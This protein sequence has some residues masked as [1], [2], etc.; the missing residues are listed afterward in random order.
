MRKVY[1]VGVG[2]T[3]FGEL[4]ERSFRDLFVEAGIRAIEDAGVDGKEIE[5]LYIGNMSAGLLV[6]QEHVASLIADH[7][8]LA[9]LHIPATRVEGGDASGALALVQGFSSIASGMY[10]V[11]VV[12]GVEK[13][14]DVMAEKASEV[15]ATTLDQEW[16]AFFGMTYASAYALMA[17]RHMHEFGTT[18]EQMALVSVKNHSNGSKN[19]MAHFRFEVSLEKVLSSPIVSYPIKLL[20]SHAVSDGASALVLCSEKKAKEFESPVEISGIG[21]ASDYIALHDRDN[22]VSMA[23][24]IEA[25]KRAYEMSGVKPEEV[26]VAEVH[27]CFTI[28]EII[29]IE[30]LGFFKKGKG[31]QATE[32]GDT[33]IGGKVAINTSGG[34]K[35]RGH[36]PGAT[37]IAQVCEIVLQLRGEAEKRQV[38]NAEIGL[39]HNLGGSGGTCVVSILRRRR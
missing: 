16:E 20:E 23:S 21:Q 12:G 33:E 19:P 18:E 4:W 2:M 26:D 5:A 29:A 9:S 24:T 13:M 14:S 39:T 35:A 22:I 11:V 1:V 17:K 28:S 10:D 32:D 31:G 36:A 27:D 15:L 6:K 7:S 25:S 30:D 37:G 34:L 38:D 3:K 8:G